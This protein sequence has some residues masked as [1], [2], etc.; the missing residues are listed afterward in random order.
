VRTRSLQLLSHFFRRSTEAGPSGGD[1]L[2][3]ELRIA[4]DVPGREQRRR[5]VE[6]GL[7]E[8][9]GVVDAAHRVTELEPGIPDR[10]PDRAGDRLEPARRR[11]VH[12]QQVDVAER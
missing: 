4:G 10:V 5:R 11:L 8:R 2:V 1:D 3:A 6:V 9:E 12:E 7:R